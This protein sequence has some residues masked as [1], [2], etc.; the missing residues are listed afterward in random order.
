MSSS[1]GTRSRRLP[2]RSAPT[3]AKISTP[4]AMP[5]RKAR[6]VDSAARTWLIEPSPSPSSA[7]RTAHAERPLRGL[8]DRV[9]PARRPRD[10]VRRVDLDGAPAHL[11]LEPH[12]AGRRRAQLVLARVVVL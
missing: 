7:R 8:V 4:T 12:E 9:R 3:A 2:S 11:L 10:D 5:I 6:P 1:G